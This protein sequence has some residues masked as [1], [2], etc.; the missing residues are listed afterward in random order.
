[1][2]PFVN[3]VFINSNET[4]SRKTSLNNVPLVV[5]NTSIIKVERKFGIFYDGNYGLVFILSYF[6]P[7]HP[8]K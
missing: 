3:T 6:A 5:E 1:M 8:H 7:I 2:L 4:G